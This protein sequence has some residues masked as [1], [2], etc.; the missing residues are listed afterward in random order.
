[1]TDEQFNLLGKLI[2]N[3]MRSGWLGCRCGH[4]GD[5]PHPCHAKAY[6]CRKPATLRFYGARPV[7]LAG[8]QMK[9]EMSDTWACDECWEM[10]RKE[11]GK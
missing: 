3:E 6:G 1:M 11:Y 8:V 4:S 9:L 2:D 5:G 10:Y 7:A